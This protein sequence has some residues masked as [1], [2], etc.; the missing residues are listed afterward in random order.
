MYAVHV[1]VCCI[2]IELSRDHTW[3]YE[4]YASSAFCN[5]TTDSLVPVR[6]TRKGDSSIPVRH[7]LLLFLSSSDTSLFPAKPMST[8]TF[9]FHQGDLPKLHIQ[10]DRGT[11][12]M[13]WKAQWVCYSSLSGLNEQSGEKQVQ[14]L[15]LC[16][17]RETLTIVQ[18]LGLS[19]DDRK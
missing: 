19:E 16:F 1:I 5:P 15:T 3:R 7:F 6:G 13:A 18:N 2:I 4:Q 11:D 14:A 17:S 12:F 8:N 9:T 10:V